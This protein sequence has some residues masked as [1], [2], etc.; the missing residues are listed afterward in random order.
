M[1]GRNSNELFPNNTDITS[2]T[3][4]VVF[5]V[6]SDDDN[7]LFVKVKEKITMYFQNLFDIA[8]SLRLR[9]LEICG[10]IRLSDFK[11]FLGEHAPHTP[12]QARMKVAKITPTVKV[13][14]I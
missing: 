13:F 8:I 9:V 2:N 3:G 6:S 14:S 1:K 4:T 11:I 10:V 7:A 12:A 5:L